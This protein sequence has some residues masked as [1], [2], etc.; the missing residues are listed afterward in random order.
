MNQ[1]ESVMVSLFSCISSFKLNL[2]LKLYYVVINDL[3]FL[4]IY[5]VVPIYVLMERINLKVNS[6]FIQRKLLCFSL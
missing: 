3:M 5:V 1:S 2:L 6:Y 4:I